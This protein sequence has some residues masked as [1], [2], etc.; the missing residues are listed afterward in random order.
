M[1]D[2]SQQRGTG[3]ELKRAILDEARRTLVEKGYP[4]LSTRKIAS[5]VGC[6]AT[7]I[8]LYFKS[9]DALVHALIEEGF[10]QLNERLE[11]AIEAGD[12]ALESLE[13]GARA[14]VD[15]GLEHPAYYEIMFMLRPERME[16]FPADSYRR[17]RRSLD[18]FAALASV[19]PEEGLRRGTIV[20]TAMH[21]LVAL[22]I[23]Q[24]IDASLDRESLIQGAIRAACAT[25]LAPPG[26]DHHGSA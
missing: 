15:Y 7:S 22:L 9:K 13:R 14:F 25:A 2:T 20:M 12:S 10:E 16:R 21:G 26:T 8:Y 18:A 4:A 19:S 5:A 11:A 24:R 23:A 6:T 17:A 1:T 3:A